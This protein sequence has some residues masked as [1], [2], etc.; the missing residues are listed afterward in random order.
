MRVASLNVN[1]IRAAVRRGLDR[2][3]ELRAPDVIGLQEVRCPPELVPP[4]PGWHLSLD[5]G[6]LAGRNGVALLTRERPSAVRTGIGH[7]A[8]AREGRYLEVDLDGAGLTVASLYLPKGDRPHA[9]AV[10][11]RSVDG[12]GAA[13]ARHRRKLRFMASLAR[14]LTDSRRAAAR[15]GREFLVMGDFNIAHTAAD[16]SNP[17]ANARSSG[18][19]PVEREWFDRLLSPRRL[20][21]VVRRLHPD[22]QGPNSWWTWRGSA[23][24][25][26]AGWRID[27]QLASPGLAAR[28][29]RAGTDR[30]PDYASRMSD[31]SPVLAD[32]ARG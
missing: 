19:L 14:Q 25:R 21:D 4:L 15:A 2:W 24:D 18:F 6:S 1:G 17:K 7:T 26:D 8:F 20:V 13:G 9:D 31:H 27:Y 22:E 11:G 30:E 10:A 23:F 5:A 29:L 3:L 32:Y 16:L 12:G 28:A